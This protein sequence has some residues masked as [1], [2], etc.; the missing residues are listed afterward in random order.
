[1]V[2]EDVQDVFP[3][4]GNRKENARS[5]KHEINIARMYISE[6]TTVYCSS[7]ATQFRLQINESVAKNL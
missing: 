2:T 6:E 5:F 4:F 7:R 1:M 3:D